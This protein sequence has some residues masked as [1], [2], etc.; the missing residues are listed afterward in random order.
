MKRHYIQDFMNPLL[1][2]QGERP[3]FLMRKRSL[4]VCMGFFHLS[5]EDDLIHLIDSFLC[6]PQCKQWKSHTSSREK[7]ITLLPQSVFMPLVQTNWGQRRR[8]SGPRGGDAGLSVLLPAGLKARASRS[9]TPTP[10]FFLIKP[11]LSS[12]SLSSS[13]LCP[14]G[15][16]TTWLW[17]E[18]FSRLSFYINIFNVVK[19]F[20]LY[21]IQG[22]PKSVLNVLLTT[23]SLSV[24][25]P[26]SCNRCWQSLIWI[27]SGL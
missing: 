23:C 17:Y 20:I 4:S 18:H 8:R 13:G 22:V 6:S 16:A 2:V 1:E 24:A 15:S 21:L 26:S 7:Q 19:F 12:I 11:S 14:Q 25:F 10:P 5:Q 9:L 27:I 3:A